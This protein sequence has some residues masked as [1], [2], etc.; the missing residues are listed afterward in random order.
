[1]RKKIAEKFD[2]FFVNIGPKLSWKIPVSNTHFEQYVKYEGPVFERKELCDEK[3][4]LF[5]KK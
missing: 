3:Y 2:N 5:T 4:F 1:M